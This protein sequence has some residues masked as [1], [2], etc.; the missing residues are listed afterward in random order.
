MGHSEERTRMLVDE[1]SS[2]P[3]RLGEMSE[4]ISPHEKGQEGELAIARE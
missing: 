4:A 2:E 3:T 1:A